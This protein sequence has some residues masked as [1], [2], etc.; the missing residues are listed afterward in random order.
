MGAGQ[1]LQNQA[2]AKSKARKG[3]K[4]SNK[5]PP[6]RTPTRSQRRP[7]VSSIDSQDT[8]ASDILNPN[9][10]GD[11]EQEPPASKLQQLNDT[12]MAALPNVHVA[13]HFPLLSFEYGLLWNINALPGE[14]MHKSV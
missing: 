14:R 8:Q 11:D 2:N 1:H 9:E 10:V 13:L 12:K 4:K 3:K 5:P 7:S 6:A